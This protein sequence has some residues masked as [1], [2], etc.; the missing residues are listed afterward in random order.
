MVN[1]CTT[2]QFC[3]LKDVCLQV[4]SKLGSGSACGFV[5]ACDQVFYFSNSSIILPRLRASIG[6]TL[7]ARSYALLKRDMRD[8]SNIPTKGTHKLLHSQFVYI[9]ISHLSHYLHKPC[10]PCHST[11]TGRLRRLALQCQQNQQTEHKETTSRLPR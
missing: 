1:R 7:A 9:P 8:M 3:A 6:V 5:L 10:K 2:P 4:V 11:E